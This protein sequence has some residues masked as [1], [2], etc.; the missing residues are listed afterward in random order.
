MLIT[1]WGSSLWFCLIE[2]DIRVISKIKIIL[3]GVRA[4]ATRKSNNK[5]LHFCIKNTKTP[6]EQPNI[7]G[8]YVSSGNNGRGVLSV[9][10]FLESDQQ[11]QRLS[12]VKL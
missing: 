4:K 5:I 11:F 8:L 6:C 10:K 7:W 1:S 12:P 9:I 3:N 2:R